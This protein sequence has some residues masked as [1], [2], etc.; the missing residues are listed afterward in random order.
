MKRA[1]NF[2]QF[3]IPVRIAYVKRFYTLFLLTIF[4]LGY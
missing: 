2:Q 4:T 3:F 1:E